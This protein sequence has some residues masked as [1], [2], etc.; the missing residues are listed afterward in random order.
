MASKSG[1]I[2]TGLAGLPACSQPH[3]EL[4]RLYSRIMR[5]LSKLPEESHYRKTT[6]NFISQRK[7][8]LESTPNH[9]DV[10]K[11]IGGGLCEEM[12]E[13]AK[14][15]LKLIETMQEYKPWEPLEDRPPQDQW[16]WPL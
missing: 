3:Q 16:K 5:A 12:I 8:I 10:E 6:E 2:L 9:E 7:S 13:Q 15:E 11:K 4:S 1:R 14:L